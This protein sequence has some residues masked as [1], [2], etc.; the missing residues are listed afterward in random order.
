MFLYKILIFFICKSIILRRLGTKIH[1]NE[2]ELEGKE[3]RILFHYKKQFFFFDG[4]CVAEDFFALT[5]K[6]NL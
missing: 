2:T 5:V 4:S 6:D 1:C 3:K